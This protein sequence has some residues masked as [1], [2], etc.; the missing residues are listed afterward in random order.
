MKCR[1]AFEGDLKSEAGADG[2]ARKGPIRDLF[3]VDRGSAPT[4]QAGHAPL[5]APPIGARSSEPIKEEPKLGS[6]EFDDPPDWATK[7]ELS[8]PPP[9]LDDAFDRSLDLGGYQIGDSGSPATPSGPAVSDAFQVMTGGQI[10]GGADEQVGK[11]RRRKSRARGPAPSPM[12]GVDGLPPDLDPFRISDSSPSDVFA[13]RSPEPQTRKRKPL[14]KPKQP[15]APVKPLPVRSAPRRQDPRADAPAQAQAAYS[16]PAPSAPPMGARAARPYPGPPPA[17]AAPMM[18]PLGQGA[19][20]AVIKRPVRD[21]VPAKPVAPA[22]AAKPARAKPSM[23]EIDWSFLAKAKLLVRPRAIV[24]EVGAVLVI[25][26]LG[27]LLFGGN[28][29]SSQA[30][31]IAGGAQSAMAGA[32]SYHVQAEVLMQTE[33]AGTIQSVVSADV[34]KDKDLHAVY[35]AAPPMPAA[36]YVTVGAK[37]YSKSGSEPWAPSTDLVNPDFSSMSLFAGAS[38]IR[39]IDKQPMDGVECDHLAFDSKP[40]FAL[41]LFPG[42]DSTPATS[43]HTEIWVDPQQKYVKHVRLDATSLETGKLGTFNCHVEVTVSGYGAPVQIAPPM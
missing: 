12:G 9:D 18:E 27:Y 36:E 35:A 38:G 26:A 11:K 37:T 8:A 21:D 34:V 15:A 30:Q 39:L 14:L 23:P 2:A 10:M 3:Q 25:I 24:A 33:K 5:D 42:V 4:R 22:R 17:Q 29:F 32:A 19:G 40:T 31:V 13:T 43:V 28:Y 41:S 6:G 1:L 16:Q 7:P 20:P